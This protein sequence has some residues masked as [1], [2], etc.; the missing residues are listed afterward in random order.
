M[1]LT[2]QPATRILL[3]SLRETKNLTGTKEGCNEGDCSTC[4][5]M[6]SSISD[7]EVQ[8]KATQHDSAVDEDAALVFGRIQR[9]CQPTN[10]I[11]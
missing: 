7:G 8:H 9:L 11:L 4:T 5:V 2:G 10:L 6:V 1:R 3:D